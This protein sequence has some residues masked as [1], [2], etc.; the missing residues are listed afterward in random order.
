MNNITTITSKD[1]P[2]LKSSRALRL[3]KGREKS[4]AFLVEG[5]KLILEAQS[6]GFDITQVFINVGALLKGEA[7]SGQFPNEI[8]L[9]EKL[10]LSLAC[11]VTPQPY[12]AV[13]K[14]PDRTEGDG[15][16]VPDRILILDRI[17][18]P[19]NAGTMIRTALAAGMDGLWCTPGTADVF[20]DKAIRASAGAVFHIETR[21]GLPVP[22]CI[23]RVKETGTKLVVCDTGGSSLYEEKLTGKLAVVVGSEAAG[24]QEGFLKAADAIIG[25]PMT[26]VSESL[27]AGIAA[28]I[29]I[30]EALRQRL[31]AA[32]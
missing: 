5:R 20:S 3:R 19:G 12:I 31:A 4:G 13:V 32:G 10:F 27:N 25:I 29:V 15:S 24:P 9:E 2:A 17:S 21:E 23:N 26:E 18:D 11:T 16:C 28:A 1:N 30:Y 6:A 22:D 8:A 7:E 14:K